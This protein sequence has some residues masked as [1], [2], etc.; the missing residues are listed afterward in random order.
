[1]FPLQVRVWSR[2][3]QGVARFI[4]SVG[5]PV[6]GCSS[7]EEAVRGADVILT[8]TGSTEPVLLGQW[9]KAGAHVA[10]ESAQTGLS[11]FLDLDPAF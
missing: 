1:M 4:S 5:G 2:S 11:G 7:A 8:V 3:K 6:Q 9:V 10:G